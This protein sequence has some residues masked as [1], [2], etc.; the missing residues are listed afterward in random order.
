MRQIEA[1]L[2]IERPTAKRGWPWEESVKNDQPDWES[3]AD[4]PISEG[5]TPGLYPKKDGRSSAWDTRRE[6]TFQLHHHENHLPAINRFSSRTAHR[7]PTCRQ[8]AGPLVHAGTLTDK[9]G[10]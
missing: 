7:L 1:D 8:R 5:T 4:H 2:R 9:L 3:R 6:I 10:H